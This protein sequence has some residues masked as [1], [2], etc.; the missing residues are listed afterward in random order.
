MPHPPLP[1]LDHAALADA[2]GTL[3]PSTEYARGVCDLLALLGLLR[4]GATSGEVSAMVVDSLRAHLADGLPFALAWD[5]LDAEGVRG[6]DVLR[7]AEAARAA[8][9]DAPTPARVVRVAQGVVKGRAGDDDR[10][11]MQFDR[12]AGQY[13]P[14]GG[15]QDPDDADSAAA[16]RREMMEE[17]G[18]PSP[19]ECALTPLL[20][21]WRKLSLSA[22]Y[23][24]LTAYAFDFYAAGAIR[25][26]IRI[27]GDTRWIGR[28][29]AGR[30]ACRRRA[31]DLVDLSRSVGPRPARRAAAGGMVVMAT[32]DEYFAQAL[33]QHRSGHIIQAVENYDRAL[34]LDPTWADVYYNRGNAR[35]AL[36]DLEGA[37]A[38]YSEAISRDPDNLDAAIN[39]GGVCAEMGDFE[40]AIA[41]FDYAISRDTSLVEAYFNRGTAYADRGDF[42][43]AATDYGSVLGLD[44]TR[45]AAYL[46]RA[47]AYRELGYYE[48]AIAD[49]TEAI[50]LSPQNAATYNTRGMVYG[51]LDNLEAAEADFSQA[52]RLNKRLVDAY[53]NRATIYHRMGDLTSAIANYE[54]YLALGGGEQYGDRADIEEAVA[55]LKAELEAGGPAEDD[56]S[57]YE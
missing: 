21:D 15:K 14:I 7:A 33:E 46:N 28:R 2:L 19:A 57:G 29:R 3:A 22:T 26:P 42:E 44:P 20:A 16:L 32:A 9:L 50:R 43:A 52:L 54:R 1:S 38:D 36:G 18:L 45:I 40:A 13:Q 12:H 17:L 5:D 23:G 53:Y 47:N 8:A 24:I 49:L 48:A 6:V 27:G 11:L 35:R 30:A 37:L 55:A 51:Q 25:F 34:N 41:D 4:D 31:S 10:Y 56:S 39:R